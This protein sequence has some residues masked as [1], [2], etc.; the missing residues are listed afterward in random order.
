[1][2]TKIIKE[3]AWVSDEYIKGNIKAVVLSFH[4]LGGGLKSAPSVEELLWIN[5][6]CLVVY[7]YSG[8]W[9]WMNRQARAMVDELV[10]A[11]YIKY[12]LSKN[13]PLIC[14]GGSM[15]GLSSLLYTRYAKRKVKACY[16]NC[17]VT[18]L[19]FHFNEREDL[20]PTIRHAFSGYKENMNQLL[21]EHS[22]LKQV[23]KLPDIPYL[24]VHGGKDKS[25]S[26]KNHSDKLVA[27]MRKRKL[28]VNYI[29][30]D[31]MGHCGPLPLDVLLEYAKFI[32]NVLKSI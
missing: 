23:S 15:G 32:E 30:I 9:S 10:E 12:K 17:P 20:P 16:A 14:T 18:D 28:N 7:P 22:P 29:E 24:I 13:I 8:P 27:L 5:N 25:V 2:E 31:Q 1:M 21:I 26:K 6:D 19:K 4:G 3:V 11:V